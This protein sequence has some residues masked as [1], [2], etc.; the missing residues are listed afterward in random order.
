MFASSPV[1]VTFLS[2]PRPDK[3]SGC[4]QNELNKESKLRNNQ[5]GIEF[6][7]CQNNPDSTTCQTTSDVHCE[8]ILLDTSVHTIHKESCESIKAVLRIPCPKKNLIPHHVKPRV[9]CLVNQSCLIQVY[10]QYIAIP[11]RVRELIHY[12]GICLPGRTKVRDDRITDVYILGRPSCNA[13][14]SLHA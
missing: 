13:Y 11:Y 14:P 12:P 10:I 4:G 9:T 1:A 7:L 3:Q 2:S 5:S 6:P 8:P